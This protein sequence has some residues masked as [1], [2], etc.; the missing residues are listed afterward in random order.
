MIAFFLLYVLIC[1]HRS[2]KK[3]S[4]IGTL[5]SLGKALRLSVLNFGAC[6]SAVIEASALA[7]V[8]LFVHYAHG[9][10]SSTALLPTRGKALRLSVLN[11]GALYISG[12]NLKKARHSLWNKFYP[13]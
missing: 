3:A 5:S 11:W 2:R 1:V 8:P 9:V 6:I 7:H 4:S 10:A 13:H 12:H